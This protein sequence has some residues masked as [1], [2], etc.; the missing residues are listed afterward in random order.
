MWR[1]PANAVIFREEEEEAAE[2]DGGGDAGRLVY[3]PPLIL[4]GEEPDFEVT[5]RLVAATLRCEAGA[6]V[7]V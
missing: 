2:V 1:P 4:A 5:D 6:G 7:P 3:Y